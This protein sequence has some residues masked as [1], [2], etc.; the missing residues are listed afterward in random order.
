MSNARQRGTDALV[1]SHYGVAAQPSESF[2]LVAELSGCCSRVLKM[3]CVFCAMVSLLLT[4]LI[5]SSDSW[6][7]VEI[8][9]PLTGLGR[10]D[11]DTRAMGNATRTYNGGVQADPRGTR[12]SWWD[13]MFGSDQDDAEEFVVGLTEA[14]EVLLEV[15]RLLERMQIRYDARRLTGPDIVQESAK[16]G[17]EDMASRPVDFPPNQDGHDSLDGDVEDLSRTWK[18]YSVGYHEAVLGQNGPLPPNPSPPISSG[19]GKL[20]ISHEVAVNAKLGFQTRV[21]SALLQAGHLLR[22]TRQVCEGVPPRRPMFRRWQDCN[23]HRKARRLQG[24]NRHVKR[25]TS[26]TRKQKRV[27]RWL[28]ILGLFAIMSA[29]VCYMMPGAFRGT[30]SMPHA[31]PRQHAH[32]GDAGPP[33]VGTATLKVPPAWSIERN[34]HY[35]LRAWISDLILW[36]TATDV[37]A[38]RMGAIAALQVSGSA[39]ELVRE[40]APEQLANGIVDP[41]T[42]Q[43]VTGLMLLVR[44]LAQRYAP[45]EGEVSTKAVSDFLNFSRIPGEA[46]DALLVRFDVLRN[47]AMLRGG[48]GVNA[49]GLSWLLLKAL[50]LS[51][52]LVDRLLQPLGGQLPQDDPQLGQ[53]L[54]RI[55]RQG[56]LFEGAMRHGSQQAGTGDPGNYLAY[57]PSTVTAC[58]LVPAASELVKF[59]QGFLSRHGEV[60][61]PAQEC[62][63][64]ELHSLWTR[65]CNAW[66]VPPAYQA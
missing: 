13:F 47:R 52:D 11:N 35:S 62:M 40:L 41:Q 48:L 51:A 60:P 50:N 10:D 26:R 38:Q 66:L 1:R 21:Q 46:I 42:G 15:E 59:G 5:V 56:H 55:R 27:K 25:K 19:L 33:F 37:E 44:T 30:G 2:D 18:D 58:P 39:K 22:S 49:S 29:L 24:R 45:L 61:P 54:D 6:E 9:E 3:C 32:V 64:Q 65:T 20:P 4:V 14:K 17:V 43:H 36:S 7:R 28:P 53:L 8:T 63:V 34:Q 16:P 12:L 23:M 31:G 57:P